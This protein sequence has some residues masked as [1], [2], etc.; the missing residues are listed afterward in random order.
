MA[1]TTIAWVSQ[2]DAS[3]GLANVAPAVDDHVHVAGNYI[4]VPAFAKNL[5]GA[6]AAGATPARA[7][8]R[9]PSIRQ[10]FYGE[11]NPM[12]SG[13]EPDSPA[14]MWDIFDS[15]FPLSEAEPMEALIQAGTGSQYNCVVAFLSD[16]PVTKDRRPHL[17]IRAVGGSAAVAYTW[18]N[19]V[20]TFS[21]TLP[22]GEYDI[23]GFRAQSTTMIA[24]RLFVPGSATRPGVLG[25]DAITDYV[26]DRFRHGEA[27]VLGHFVHDTPPVVQILCTAADAA[28]TQV[29]WF[30]LVRTA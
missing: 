4:Y 3:A 14:P 23:V 2:V 27:G 15:P 9:S 13:L 26:R 11:I 5:A 6:Y 19:S 24:A 29:F 10:L 22:A 7:Q 16:G 28:N 30:D 1:Y 25:S 18:T 17:T 8:L 12:S 20:P 21:D